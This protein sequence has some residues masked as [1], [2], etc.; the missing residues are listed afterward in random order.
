[1]ALAGAV[2]AQFP[3]DQI[4]PADALSQFLGTGLVSLTAGAIAFVLAP[5]LGRGAAAGL[6][7]VALVAAYVIN[8]YAAVL[9]SLSA[10]EGLSWLHWTARHRP[11][12]GISDPGPVAAVGVLD[13]ALLVLGV[14]VFVRRDIGSTMSLPT[15]PLPG[16]RFGLRGPARR[17]FVSRLP[18][19]IAWGFGIGLYGLIIAAS[20]AGFAK[21]FDQ[22]QGLR[23]I[24]EQFYP[25]IDY[26]SASGVLQLAFVPFGTLLAGLAVAVLVSGWSSD[27]RERRLDVVLAGP[28]SRVRWV[29]ASGS[30]VLAAIAVMAVIGALL[31][32]AGAAIDGD[33]AARP[34]IGTIVIGLYAAALAGVGLALGGLVGPGLAAGVTAGLALGFYLL[35]SLGT[36]LR[37]PDAV[38]T[39]ALS[40]HLGQPIIGTYASPGMVVCAG[41]AAGGVLVAAWGLNRRDVGR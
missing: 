37:L 39:L 4:S 30:G 7:A 2:F 12:A 15:L 33:D 41:L 9:P 40:R 8:S 32:A 17:S 10:V 35:D 14:V 1:V 5:I 20:A 26:R 25:G 3:G 22:I 24:I 19:A 36:A 6:A 31:V 38:L 18:A 23:R 11:L 16:V 27:E 21:A 29:I 34:F 13:A 28:I